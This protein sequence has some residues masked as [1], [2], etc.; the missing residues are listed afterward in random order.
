[1]KVSTIENATRDLA[2]PADWDNDKQ[3]HCSSLPVADIKDP[4]G[5][6]WMASAWKPEAEEIT[7]INRGSPVVLYV[8]GTEAAAHP[9]V[10]LAVSG[11]S[12]DENGCAV[13]SKIEQVAVL[14]EWQLVPKV[15]T[16]EM[17]QAGVDYDQLSPYREPFTTSPQGRWE[18]QLAAAPQPPK[19]E[20]QASALSRYN[21]LMQPGE[22]PC[23]IERLRFF[24]SNALNAQDWLDVES[25][26]DAV[27]APQP[28]AAVGGASEDAAKIAEKWA[29][30]ADFYGY[31]G[32]AENYRAIA[33]EIRALDLQGDSSPCSLPPVGWKCTRTA[34]HDG[35]CAAVKVQEPNTESNS[36]VLYAKGNELAEAKTHD[37]LIVISVQSKQDDVFDTALFTSPQAQAGVGE[38]VKSLEFCRDKMKSSTRC[39]PNAVEYLIAEAIERADQALASVKVG[40]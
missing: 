24:L 22:E 38:L 13:Q 18:T 11:V 30:T 16:S 17:I 19:R 32:D 31:S 5:N 6:P 14:V 8:Y 9:V 3:G 37:H 29:E 7:A 39:H 25:F 1:M 12:Y 35:P 36:A 21:Q 26:I 23:P 15:L 20:K 10:G 34:G 40:E 28:A 4:Q 27:K 2:K 33:A